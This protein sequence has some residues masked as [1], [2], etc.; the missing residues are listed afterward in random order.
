[1]PKLRTLGALALERDGSP[2]GGRA[3]QRRRL[4]LLALL[5]TARDAT[6]PRDRLLAY[7]WPERATDLARHSLSQTIYALRQELGDDAILGGADEVRLNLAVVASDVAEFERARAAGDLA[8]AAELY[9]GPFLDGFFVSDAAE[10]GSWVESERARLARAY[11]EALEGLARESSIRDPSAAA[12]WWR[13][14]AALDSMDSRVALALIRALVDA[15]DRAGALRH[16]RVHDTLL[17]QELGLPPDAGI[18]RVVRGLRDAQAPDERSGLAPAAGAAPAVLAPDGGT[19]GVAPAA[20]SSTPLTPSSPARPERRWRLRVPM[21]GAAGLL[22]LASTLALATLSSDEAPVARRSVLV[23]SIVGPDATLG[24]AVREAFLAELASEPRIRLL[25]DAAIR[26]TLRLMRL[27]PESAMDATM[28]SDVAQRSGVP[29]VVTGS[30]VPIGNGVLVTARLV[31]A[32]TGAT[33]LVLN[34]SPGASDQ[35]IPSVVRL[36]RGLRERA[37]GIAADTTER[38]LPAVTTSSVDALRDYALA[39]R[40]AAWGDRRT[41]IRLLESAIAHDSLFAL[42][43]YLI[44]DLFWYVDQ[45]SRSD[46]HLAHALALSHRLPARERLVVR[47]RV[48]QL[49]NDRPDSALAYWRLLRDA[50][51]DEPLAFEGMIWAYRALGDLTAASALADTAIRLEPYPTLPTLQ[52]RLSGL[53]TSGDTA[54]ARV[55]VER[56]S[57]RLGSSSADVE[58]WGQVARRDWTAP[59]ARARESARAAE[60]ASDTRAQTVLLMVGELAEAERFMS[61]IVAENNI[62]NPPR[63]LLL[64]ARAEL[65][66]GGSREH[67]SALGREALRWIRAADLSPPAYARLAERL[68]DV[69]ARASDH[70]LLDQTRAFIEQRDAGRGLRSY[71]IALRTLAAQRAF[72]ERRYGEAAAFAAAAQRETFFGRSFSTVTLLE[73]DALRR[74]GDHTRADAITAE[75]V[76]RPPSRDGDSESWIL[77]REIAARR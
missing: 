5:A 59:L 3:T 58:W 39:R 62:Q 20:T 24:L 67:A 18:A 56:Y 12:G 71:R 31:D 34:A 32:T 46:R 52:T 74:A 51:V 4:A 37:L 54:G 1:M 49:V 61:A 73:R 13:R 44:G 21:A 45:Q 76:A 40:A 6:M 33:L 22:L 50:Y 66:L 2:I 17:Q 43:H 38:P 16:A 11:G 48:E 77:L 57:A 15:G 23:G 65:A 53:L 8:R 47:A 60:V 27:P 75:L 68:G 72:M 26:A 64:Q 42:A 30:V 55:F 63:A 9:G 10:F 28:A 29:L 7:L 19:D 25:D 69:A 36:A 35:I 14:R 41:A 70:G